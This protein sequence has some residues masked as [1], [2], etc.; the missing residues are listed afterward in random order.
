M[1]QLDVASGRCRQPF[2]ILTV[3]RHN[4]VAVGRQQHDSGIN[5]ICE[6]RGT[7]ESSC[8]PAERLIEGADI[9]AIERL[10]QTGLTGAAAPHLPKHP[11]VGQ[12]EVSVEL[13][14]LQAD[15]HLA[16]IALQRHKRA[17][18]ENEAHADF[19]RRVP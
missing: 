4:L 11:G 5:D 14:G 1:D 7:E 17:A 13:G 3:D 19:A 16:F 12:W 2:E 8:S 6:A 10:R 18:V 15:P 9:D